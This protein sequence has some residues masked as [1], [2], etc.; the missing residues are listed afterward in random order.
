M[1]NIAD[2]SIIKRRSEATHEQH[3]PLAAFALASRWQ[4]IW[5]SLYEFTNFIA[6]SAIWSK[7]FFLRFRI[8]G[9]TRRIVETDMHHLGFSRKYGTVFM[10]MTA[11]GYDKIEL[12][13]VQFIHELR[14]MPG[15]IHSGFRHRPDGIGIQAVRGDACRKRLDRV[16]FQV[17]S[18][19]FGHLA[20]ARIA[21]AKEQDF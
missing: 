14:A 7:A 3:L 21:G 8:G 1:R 11:N 2:S 20:A 12:D 9:K 17:A 18:P 4:R 6:H 10:S 5:Q 16:A 15:D 13:A 19:A